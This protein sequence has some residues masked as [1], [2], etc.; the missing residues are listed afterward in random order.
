MNVKIEKSWKNILRPEF[1][2]EY[3][4]KLTDFVKSEY[5]SETIYPPPRFI[6]NAFNT[7]PFKD[8]KVV[9][10]GQDPYHGP[11]Q[12]HGLSFSVLPPT[13]P[14]PSLQN[15][16]K[17]IKDNLGEIENVTGDLTHWAKQG[18]LL[19]NATLTV[20]AKQAGSHQ[21][22]GWEAFTDSVI[23]LISKKKTGVVFILWGNYAR[24]KGSNIDR[25]KHLVLESPHPSPFSAHSGF[26]GSQP[27]SQTN[28]YLLLNGKEP[29]DW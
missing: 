15:I 1:K 21:E 3:F 23:D 24:K 26:F 20:K 12:A 6:F 25:Q 9:I 16:Y 8:V 5:Q 10:L 14:P 4:K 28:A 29:I 18:V 7:T 2:K 19:L 17:E 13:K 22:K 11:N 27:F